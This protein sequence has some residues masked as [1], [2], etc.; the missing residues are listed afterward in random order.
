M[1][2]NEIPFAI[3]EGRNLIVFK[4]ATSIELTAKAYLIRKMREEFS[5]IANFKE[6]V[7]AYVIDCKDY[8]NEISEEFVY[9]IDNTIDKIAINLAYSDGM[10]ID[11]S[12]RRT[13]THNE[14]AQFCNLLK[15]IIIEAH[16]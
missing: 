4:G 15:S 8:Y 7:K 5:H 11:R 3:L 14:Q 9:D 1:K 12:K 10:L 16:K 13:V 2:N 6:R